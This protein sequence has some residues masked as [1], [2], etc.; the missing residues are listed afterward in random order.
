MK[1]LTLTGFLF[2]VCCVLN[3]Q[4][5]ELSVQTGHSSGVNSIA[6]SPGDVWLASAGSDNKIILWDFLTARQADVFIGHNMSVTDIEFHPSG[7][8]LISSSLD[9]TIK[10]WDVSAGKCLSSIKFS[11]PLF[12]VDCEASGSDIVVAGKEIVFITLTDLLK[13]NNAGIDKRT[14]L[15]IRAKKYFTT[16]AFSYDDQY[17][18]FGGEEEDLGYLI[19]LNKREVIRKFPAAFSDVFFEADNSKL[20]YSTSLG[21][22]AEISLSDRKKKGT[23][24]DWMLNAFNAIT[25]DSTFIYLANDRGEIVEIDRLTFAENRI[26]KTTKSRLNT[27]KISNSGHFI[28][29]GGEN[30]RI[31][32]WDLS[33]GLAVKDFEGSV[34]QIN[35][36]L[37]SSDGKDILIGYQDGSLRKTNLFSNQ[38]IV[39]SPQ[40]NSQILNSRFQWSVFD[41]VSFE[42]DS[43][44]IT[45]HKKRY[46]L[47]EENTFDK[48]TEYTV[49]WIFKDNYLKLHEHKFLGEQAQHYMDDRKS[50]ITNPI[51]FLLNKNSLECRSHDGNI[52]ITSD[53]KEIVVHEGSLEKFKIQSAHSDILTSVSINETYGFFATAGWDGLIRFYDINTSNLISTFGPFGNGQFIYINPDGYYFSSKKALDYVGFK[54]GEKF[55]SFEQFDLIYNRPDL[56]ASYLP[57]F[58]DYYVSA[59]KKA[60][61]KRL[62]KLEL[63]EA[64]LLIRED[65]PS[66]SYTRNLGNLL[67]DGSIELI[68]NCQDM[69]EELD[70]LHVRVNGVPEYGRF[71]KSIR[72]HSYVDSLNVVLN[73]GTNYIQLYCTNKS[74]VASLKES[75]TLEAHK[76]DIESDLYLISIGVSKYLE[77]QYNL[78]YAAKDAEDVVRFFDKPYGP[79]STVH[80]KLLV[81]TSVTLSAVYDLKDLLLQANQND[82]VILFIAGHGVLDLN[83]DYYLATHDMDFNNPSEKGIP[84]DLF[85]ELLD[86]TKSRKK[87]MFIDACHSGEIDKDDVIKSET[88]ESEQGDIK[89]RSAGIN[90]VN[91]EETNVLDLAKSLFADMRLNNGTTVISSAGGNEFAIESDNWKNGAFTYCFL[92]G[93][94]SGDADLNKNKSITLSEIQEYLLFQVNKLTEG[95]QTPTSRVE[96][97]NNDFVIR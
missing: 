33:T 77:H 43:A 60:Y 73:P 57:Y 92:Y 86:H 53:R 58:D 2:S 16:V 46:A 13:S 47:D 97:L 23:S 15:P 91:K 31:V 71:G 18:A 95:A 37:F 22:A 10:I 36:V 50:G 1:L 66:I 61:L 51:S 59:Y 84:Y 90:I 38:S 28:A 69:T 89:F 87:V 96:N 29:S 88:I 64:D 4:Q 20:L 11:Y 24:T 5:I 9:S 39:N 41:I 67:T 56:V 45:M 94:S 62:K 21:L 40:I 75:F 55:Y 34:S 79:F 3:A 70:R 25:A 44:V 27:L 72:D 7:K 8:Y 80:T 26:F 68:I 76:R 83:F 48:I 32:L 6:F 93:L 81:D 82:V 74:G 17:L 35:D 42:K 85:D 65:V 14:A 19:D 52:K 54:W 63:T 12:S 30:G 49:V 78:N